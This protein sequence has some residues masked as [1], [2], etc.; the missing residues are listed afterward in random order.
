MDI[1]TIYAAVKAAMETEIRW[2]EQNAWDSYYLDNFHSEI[3]VYVSKSGEVTARN[4]WK[5]RVATNGWL[6][7]DYGMYARGEKRVAA[8]IREF[9]SQE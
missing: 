4:T 7:V 1:N 9:L 8:R 6:K 5:R 2:A 3:A